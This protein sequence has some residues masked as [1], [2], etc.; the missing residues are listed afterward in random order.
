M[1]IR[2]GA[3]PGPSRFVLNVSHFE[4]EGVGGHWAFLCPMPQ[5]GR[6]R[7]KRELTVELPDAFPGEIK[8]SES[9]AFP[10]PRSALN[11]RGEFPDSRRANFPPLGHYPT[12]SGA[13]TKN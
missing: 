8:R 5:V 7:S 6:E 13:W 2:L 9:S 3:R 1:R 4:T 12:N 11:P 10:N